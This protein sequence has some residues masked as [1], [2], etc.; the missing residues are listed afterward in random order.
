MKPEIGHNKNTK[1]LNGV[2][3]SILDG[4]SGSNEFGPKFVP[5]NAIFY[6]RDFIRSE[7]SGLLIFNSEKLL[8]CI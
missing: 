1:G 8:V 6:V 4:N 2:P 3:N 5:I 7:A